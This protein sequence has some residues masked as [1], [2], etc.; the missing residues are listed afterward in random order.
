MAGV[1]RVGKLMLVHLSRLGYF[2]VIAL[3]LSLLMGGLPLHRWLNALLV[4]IGTKLVA[5]TLQAVIAKER[6]FLYL[7]DYLR[8]MLVF[9]LVAALAIGLAEAVVELI[10]GKI[11]VPLLA[12]AMVMAWRQTR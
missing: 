8:E 9:S 12:A 11:W 5:D 2:A 6:Q 4:F 10:G 3:A 7:E 1:N